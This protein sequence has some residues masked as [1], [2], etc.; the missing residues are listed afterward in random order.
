ML[1]ESAVLGTD[2]ALRTSQTPL[3][4]TLQIIS[5]KS[6]VSQIRVNHPSRSRSASAPFPPLLPPP[7]PPP[8]RTCAATALPLQEA[9]RSAYPPHRHQQLLKEKK[10]KRRVLLCPFTGLTPLME[11]NTHPH[12]KFANVPP[13]HGELAASSAESFCAPAAPGQMLFPSRPSESQGHPPS[14]AG[15]AIPGVQ[16]QRTEVHR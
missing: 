2:W 15:V 10:K 5:P 3:A 6:H 8:P 13:R 4:E 14:E 16:M 9:A 11:F 1:K 12:P 7:T